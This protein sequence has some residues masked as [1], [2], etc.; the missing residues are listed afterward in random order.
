[1]HHAQEYSIPSRSAAT[2]KTKR[3]AQEEAEKRENPRIL[4]L[5]TTYKI[6]STGNIPTRNILVESYRPIKKKTLWKQEEW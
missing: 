2:T 4:Q 5:H 1:M 6:D 3:Q